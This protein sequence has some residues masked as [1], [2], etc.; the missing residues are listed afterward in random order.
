[1]QLEGVA[2]EPSGDELARLGARYLAVFPDGVER[3]ATS[4]IAYFRVRPRWI[5]IS[6]FACVPPRI[7]RVL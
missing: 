2:D 1:V 7:E 4:T 5:R 3:A 6:D